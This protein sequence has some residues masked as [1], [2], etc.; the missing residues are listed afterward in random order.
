MSL[1]YYYFEPSEGLESVQSFRNNADAINYA[2]E[3]FDDFDS[4]II[5]REVT[6]H[7]EIGTLKNGVFT[8]TEQR[9]TIE[10]ELIAAINRLTNCFPVSS[11]DYPDASMARQV[12]DAIEYAASVVTKAKGGAK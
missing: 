12:F 11:N 7:H 4:V 5:Q 3:V 8:P 2:K 10:D 1:K 6:E 9:P